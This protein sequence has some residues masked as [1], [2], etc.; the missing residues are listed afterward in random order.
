MGEG[1]EG[2][3]IHDDHVGGRAGLE[4]AQGLFEVPGADFGVVFKEHPG[5]LPPA[6]VGQAG[7]VPLH[8][9]EHLQALQHVVGV[10]VGTQADEDA[11]LEQLEHRRAAHRVAHVGFRV[12]AHHGA[13]LPENVHLGGGDVDAV[14]QHGLF[15]QHAVVEQAVHR[16]AAV[17]PEGVVHVVHAL[18]HMDVEAGHTVVGLHHLLEGL[19]G[20][21]EQGVAAEHG[22]D[23]VVVLLLRPPGEV[24]VLPDGLAAL[25]CAVPL[26][27]LIAE[28]GPDAQLLTHVLDG[29]EG[30]GDFAE[31]GVVVEDGGHTVPDAVQHR[32]V[33]AGP[34]AVQGQMSVDVPP[35][36]VQHLQEVG[37]V[38]PVDGQAPGQARVDVGVHVDE[39]G[40]DDAPPGVHKL[41]VGV[42]GPQL[43]QGPHLL[44]DLA[45]QRHRAVLRIGEGL[46]PGNQSSVSNQQHAS[47]LLWI[48]TNKKVPIPYEWTLDSVTAVRQHRNRIPC[49]FSPCARALRCSHNRSSNCLYSIYSL[50]GFTFEF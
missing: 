35:L 27:D 9:Q 30:A 7:V 39:A 46:V 8:G 20:D 3:V 16:A 6:H 47:F 45:V 26:A 40:H 17:V 23:H 22:L 31:G 12:V 32:G 10:G 4:H 1:G 44:D 18:G 15:P 21:G 33:G 43:G 49:P 37:G 29:E 38:E 11:L 50:T 28:V 41:G 2:L 24:G 34:G 42:F 14:A 48:S 19:V 5:G 25:L 36:A 13:R